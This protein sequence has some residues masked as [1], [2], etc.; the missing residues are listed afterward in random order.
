MKRDEVI[1]VAELLYKDEKL[2][3]DRDIGTRIKLK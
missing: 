3:C 1:Q 2:I